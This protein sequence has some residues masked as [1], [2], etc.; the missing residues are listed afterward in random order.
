MRRLCF[1]NAG[2]FTHDRPNGSDGDV[3]AV[4]MAFS[5]VWPALIRLALPLP[6]CAC[7]ATL[8]ADAG[9]LSQNEHK[10]PGVSFGLNAGVFMNPGATTVAAGGG[11]HQAHAFAGTNSDYRAPTVAGEIGVPVG[12]GNPLRVVGAFSYAPLV[13]IINDSGPE[14]AHGTLWSA[15]LG[16]GPVVDNG[17]Q[18]QT[19]HLVL[20]P[21][22]TRASNDHGD[23][24]TAGAQLRFT[25]GWTAWSGVA[26]S[27][28]HGPSADM[29][30]DPVD[31]PPSPIDHTLTT[32]PGE[33]KDARDTRM[34]IEKND[35]AQKE[36]ERPKR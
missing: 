36:R 17:L 2:R 24:W 12:T 28:A 6:L 32:Q 22:Y 35:A 5:R 7:F 21:Q 23:L 11:Y 16:I 33:S 30:P 14:A 10:M 29:I 25:W 26:D 27:A 3:G 20:G 15:F 19:G 34:L 13:G 1:K 8:W 18:R 31:V 4:W 9:V